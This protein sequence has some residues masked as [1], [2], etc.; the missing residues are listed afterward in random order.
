V[1]I[2]CADAGQLIGLRRFDPGF[3]DHYRWLTGFPLVD[4][5][6]TAPEER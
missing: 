5:E 4:E 2:V 1:V 3:T 6:G